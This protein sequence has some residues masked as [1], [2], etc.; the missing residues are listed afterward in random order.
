M[1]KQQENKIEDFAFEFLKRHYTEQQGVKNI[2]VGKAEKNKHGVVVD[3]L[4]AFMNPENAYFLATVTFNGTDKLSTFLN[5]YKKSG[6]GKLRFGTPF[7]VLL[8]GSGLNFWLDGGK[9][10]WAAVVLVALTGFILHTVLLK[11]YLKRSINKF[12]DKLKAHQANEQ[13]LGLS[14]SSLAFRNNSLARHLLKLCKRRGIGIITVGKRAKVVVMQEPHTNI[15]RKGDFLSHFTSEQ[16]IRKA[17]QD[18]TVLRV[19]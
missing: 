8:M 16:S 13:W 15:C 11:V 10:G 1:P 6:L 7:L 9:T 5:S 17:I 18:D 3:G 4:F 12:V 19:A 2:L 14:I